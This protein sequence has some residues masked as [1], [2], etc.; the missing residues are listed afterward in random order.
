[1]TK[2][3]ETW[4][5]TGAARGIGFEYVKQARRAPSVCRFSRAPVSCLPCTAW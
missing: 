5:V 1:M 2:T 3:G 4:V